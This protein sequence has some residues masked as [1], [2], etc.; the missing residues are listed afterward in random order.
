VEA[1][2]TI[3]SLGDPRSYQVDGLDD[4]YGILAL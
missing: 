4:R 1:I 2:Y 3:L